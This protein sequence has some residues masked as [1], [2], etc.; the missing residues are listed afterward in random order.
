MKFDPESMKYP[1]KFDKSKLICVLEENDIDLSIK[2]NG[3]RI[4]FNF[5]YCW[6][7][8]W[9]VS[10]LDQS[11]PLI[12][13]CC[14]ES[15][16]NINILNQPQIVQDHFPTNVLQYVDSRICILISLWVDICQQIILK[17]FWKFMLRK[18]IEYLK[19]NWYQSISLMSYHFSIGFYEKIMKDFYKHWFIRWY[20]RSWKKGKTQDKYGVLI[21]L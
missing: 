13:T 2:S 14:V 21:D 1:A 18:V 16:S 8:I 20:T 9:R 12:K 5:Y 7:L 3:S 10:F 17:Q 19:D 4:E 11:S 15:L 6:R